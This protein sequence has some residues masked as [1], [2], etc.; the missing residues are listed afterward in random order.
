[1]GILLFSWVAKRAAEITNM[2]SRGIAP[3]VRG[4]RAG[5]FCAGGSKRVIF[6]HAPTAADHVAN[7]LL[8]IGQF[9]SVV[10]STVDLPAGAVSARDRSTDSS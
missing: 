9:V 3:K 8:R 7:C 10:R 5:G 1:M 6:A 2:R 4:H